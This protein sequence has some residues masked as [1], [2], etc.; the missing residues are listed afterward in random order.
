MYK[1]VLARF[2]RCNRAI[3]VGFHCDTDSQAIG[4]C[5]E[6]VGNGDEVR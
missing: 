2:G 1:G 6:N 3:Q 5:A 4:C